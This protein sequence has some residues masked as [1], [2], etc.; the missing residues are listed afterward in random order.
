MMYKYGLLRPA[1]EFKSGYIYVLESGAIVLYLGRVGYASGIVYY[2]LGFCEL[3]KLFFGVLY[4]CDLCC[5][6]A[7]DVQYCFLEPPLVK[8]SKDFTKKGVAIGIGC[9][10][11]LISRS[12]ADVGF[13]FAL[14]YN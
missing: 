1:S 3:Q 12:L 11:D 6:V 14:K 5:Y 10:V 8:A 2:T 4:P 9:S 13:D 7:R